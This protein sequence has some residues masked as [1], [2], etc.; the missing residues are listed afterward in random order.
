MTRDD[1]G[2]LEWDTVSK[3]YTLEGDKGN[4]RLG[5]G[6]DKYLC[7]GPGNVKVPKIRAKG[8]MRVP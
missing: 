3:K 4:G 8:R 5:P 1:E 7:R 6:K 2:I